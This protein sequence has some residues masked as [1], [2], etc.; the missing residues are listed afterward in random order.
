[1]AQ[2]N[3]KGLPTKKRKSLRDET[4]ISLYDTKSE[5]AYKY[6]FKELLNDVD[7]LLFDYKEV[8][9]SSTEILSC[10][11]TPVVLLPATGATNKYYDFKIYVEYTAGTDAYSMGSPFAIQQG[12]TNKMPFGLLGFATQNAIAIVQYSFA[13]LTAYYFYPNQDLVLTTLSGADPTLGNGTLKLKIYY[14][15][16]TF[17]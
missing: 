9:V 10:G 2:T 7:G 4:F 1:M 15:I 6:D 14:K 12:T 11:S 16:K 13:T 17:G 3:I 8:D 5:A